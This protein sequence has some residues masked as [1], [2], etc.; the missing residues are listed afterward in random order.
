MIRARLKPLSSFAIIAVVTST[1]AMLNPWTSSLDDNLKDFWYRLY[2]PSREETRIAVV[3]IDDGTLAHYAPQIPL[4][5]DQIALA[6]NYLAGPTGNARL[7]VLDLCF[8]GDDLYDPANDSILGSVLGQYQDRIVSAV[9]IPMSISGDGYTPTQLPPMH[10]T[11]YQIPG[12]DV[13]DFPPG[14]LNRAPL[15][16]NPELFGH[17]DIYQ[18]ASQITKRLPMFVR[19]GDL[20]ISAISFEAARVY[21]GVPK[22]ELAYDRYG[23]LHC[24]SHRVPLERDGTYSIRYFQ[25]SSGYERY[26]FLDLLR[27]FESGELPKDLFDGKIVLIGVNSRTHYP[28]ELTFTPRGHIRPSVYTHADVISNILSDFH[29]VKSSRQTTIFMLIAIV[30]IFSA[31]QFVRSRT[32]RLS[33]A[34][35]VVVIATLTDFVSFHSGVLLLAVPL[36]ITGIVLATYTGFGIFRQQTHIIDEQ[37]RQMF[38]LGTRE[39]QLTR[40]EQELHVAR[41][42]QEHLLPQQLPSIPGFQVCGMNIPAQSVSGDFYDVILLPDKR[43]LI[44]LGDV[45]GKGISA[46]LLMAATQAIIRSESTRLPGRQDDLIELAGALNRLLCATTDSSRFV[47][48]V[49]LLL[50][51]TTREMRLVNAGHP[52]PLV[53]SPGITPTRITVG[54]PPIGISPDL[55]FSDTK[56]VLRRD[57]RV[58]VVSDGVTEATD[59]SEEMYGEERLCALIAMHAGCSA[60]DIASAIVCDVAQFSCNTSSDDVTVVVVAADYQMAD[61]TDDL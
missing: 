50:D 34:T 26:S 17:V 2:M 37:V 19:Q 12:L 47:T 21:L 20:T 43:V 44:T 52:N 53:T 15:S 6:L 11:Q 56:L 54:D 51:P 45:S 3:E 10:R 35:A 5:R 7:V 57:Q 28:K 48:L 40:L 24:G 31:L 30:V 25:N 4:P 32:L 36:L 46:S 38:T 33:G 8:E 61:R 27:S 58:V 13:P 18:D 14:G 55:V 42:I 60:N 59:P 22:E 16:D 29:L 49:L 9:F 23:Y 1:A 39:K 41:V